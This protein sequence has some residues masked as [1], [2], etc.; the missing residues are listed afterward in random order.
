MRRREYVTAVGGS[1]GALASTRIGTAQTVS[2]ERVCPV[3][4]ATAVRPGGEILFEAAAAPGVE[5][6]ATEWRIDGPDGNEIDPG[7]PFY[8]YTHVTGQPAAYGRFDEPGTCEVSVAAAGRSVSWT[9][10]VT[11]AAPGSPS[12]EVTPDPGPDA[13]ITVRDEIEV[14]ASAADDFGTL[15]RL[16]WQEGRNATYVDSTDFSGSTATA[17]YETTGGDAVWFIGDYPMMT[18]VACRDGRL[19]TARTEGPSVITWR[20]VSITGTNAPVRA[21]EDLLVEAEIEIDG[22][23]TYHAFVD[24]AADLIVGHDPTHVDSETLEVFAGN[25]ET[26]QLEFTTATVRN[27]QTFPVRVETRTDASETDVTVIG[28]DDAG[29]QGHLDVTG[30]ETNAPVTG[31]ERLEVT[32][33]LENTGNGP[34]DRDVEL[35][36]GHDPTTVDT[37]SVIVDAGEAT[38]VSLGYETY[39]VENDDEFPVRVGTGDDTASQTVLVHGRSGNGESGQATFAISVT[40]TNA[41]VTG[42]EWL[43]ATAAVENVGDAAGT[44]DIEL[45]VGRTPEVV[46]ATSVT[47]APDETATVSLGYET[48]PVRNDDTFPV[49]IR[50]PHASDTRTVTVHGRG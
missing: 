28:T 11:E 35:V 7:A 37:R 6:T 45:V 31:G 38:T 24:V 4:D 2:L 3:D 1:V 20:G 48:Y 13:T 29:S 30:L 26:V 34:A 33:A 22:D 9:V 46:D 5:P 40:G 42:G 21:G 47:L 32:A 27:T 44:Q 12:V 43:S 18:W 23:S 50:S 41:P 36:V 14:A 8:S 39:P 16:F 17:T 15:R 10:E 49:T 19:S 25:T